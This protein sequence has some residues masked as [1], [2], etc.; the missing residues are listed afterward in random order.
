MG[1][2]DG[3]AEVRVVGLHSAIVEGEP[4]IF[5]APIAGGLVRLNRWVRRRL[6]SAVQD[7]AAVGETAPE[8]PT[9]TDRPGPDRE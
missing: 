1:N 9:Q 7:D 4:G 6:G 8:E 3:P 2:A 5:P